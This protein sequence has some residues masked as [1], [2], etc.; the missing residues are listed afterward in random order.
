MP[1]NING[2]IDENRDFVADTGD[3]EESNPE[4]GEEEK[5]AVAYLTGYNLGKPRKGEEEENARVVKAYSDD[6]F[7]ELAGLGAEIPTEVRLS[8]SDMGVVLITVG[9][10][11]RST[12]IDELKTVVAEVLEGRNTTASESKI[13]QLAKIAL[14]YGRISARVNKGWEVPELGVTDL[15][16]DAAELFSF[17]DYDDVRENPIRFSDIRE[18]LNSQGLTIQEDWRECSEEVQSA[19]I[20]IAEKVADAIPD[21][22]L[23]TSRAKGPE[24][25]AK[26]L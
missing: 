3:E 9:D 17:N 14:V 21:T 11:G 19:I 25:R 22:K 12:D 5:Q 6:I 18:F 20:S 23:V 10:S 24:V 8:N 2:S 15:V 7:S 13:N 4:Y 26:K 16:E 1:E